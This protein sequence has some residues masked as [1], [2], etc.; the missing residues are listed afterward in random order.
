LT[1]GGTL[2]YVGGQTGSA[3][4]SAVSTVYYTSSISSGAPTWNGTAAAGGIGDTSGQAAQARTQF[5]G[6]VWNNRL[7]VVGGYSGAGAVQSTVYVSPQ[8]N[9]GG[10]ISAD[11]WTSSTTFNVARAG[12]STVA[13]ANNLYLFGGEETGGNYLNDSQFTQI[14]SDG[15]VDAWVYSTSLPG[16]IR[17]AEG[18]AANGYLYLIGGRS[19]ATVCVPNT[20]VTP[21][22]ANTTIATGNNPTGVGEW[23]ETNKK[24]TGDRYGAAVAYANGRAYVLGGACNSAFV[25]GADRGYQTTLKS[26]PQVAKYSRMVDTD[27]DVFANSWLLNGLD[28]S[29]GARWYLRYRSMTDIDG[30][31][32]D[33]VADMTSWGQEYNHGEVTLGNVGTLVPRDGSGTNT[34]CARYYYFSVYIDSSQ[35]FGYPE[36]VSRGPTITDLSLFYTADPSKRMLHGKTFTGG[37]QQP[38]DTPCRRGS[39]VSG[40][41]NYNCPLP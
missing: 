5:G 35:A 4:T 23:Y 28:N 14:N 18:F 7:Y 30:V 31:T 33:C 25:A 37:E 34:N 16:K 27:V 17:D 10:A 40:D 24:Y 39:A 32:A 15:S 3:A 22:S 13:Y 21:I 9:S 38:L 26:Q 12:L 19:A 11:A 41:P 2:Y 29:T 8:L 6:A 36:D 1:A 20:L